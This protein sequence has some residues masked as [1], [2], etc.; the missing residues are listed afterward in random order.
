MVLII[1][2]HPC[3]GYHHFPYEITNPY[4]SIRAILSA[5]ISAGGQKIVSEIVMMMS[6]MESSLSSAC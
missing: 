1:K 4:K 6:S 3:Q 5:H 2:G